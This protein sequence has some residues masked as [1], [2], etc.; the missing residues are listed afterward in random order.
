MRS[1]LSIITDQL[2]ASRATMIGVLAVGIVATLMTDL[3]QRLLQ[4]ALRLPPA[5][6]G[7]IGRWVACMPRGV[8]VHR[9][10]T[11]TSPVRGELAIGWGFHYAVG[12]AYA[13]LYLAMV[14]LLLGSGPTLVS[15]LLFGIA[16]L[17]A[18]WFVMQPALGLGF[19][20]ARTPNPGLTRAI[21]ASVHAMFGLGLYIG[22]VIFVA[23]VP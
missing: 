15:A 3:W 20:A 6:W 22:A 21:T 7:L 9:S 4:A 16:L 11:S 1:Y 17:V 10:I 13:A 23:G 8:L 12:I 14:R 19:M 18:P 5:N 2:G